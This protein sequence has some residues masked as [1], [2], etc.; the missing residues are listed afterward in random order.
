MIFH[1]FSTLKKSNVQTLINN[2]SILQ[3]LCVSKAWYIFI[4]WAIDLHCWHVSSLPRTHTLTNPA[5]FQNHAVYESWISHHCLRSSQL[6]SRWLLCYSKN[7]FYILL[8]HL[9]VPSFT[10]Q[11]DVCAGGIF[12]KFR[13]NMVRIEYQSPTKKKDMKTVSII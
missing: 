3:V 12:K 1:N 11:N 5:L 10:V 6:S 9:Y 13:Q 8:L 2:K 4:V 7:V